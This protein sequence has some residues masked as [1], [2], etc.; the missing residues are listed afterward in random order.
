MFP[1]CGG[2]GKKKK[3]NKLSGYRQE[4]RQEELT[5][6]L[7]ILPANNYGKTF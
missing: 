1:E 5:G 7:P 4:K 2:K 6:N 3:W